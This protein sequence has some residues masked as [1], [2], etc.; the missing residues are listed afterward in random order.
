MIPTRL[1]GSLEFKG[2][3]QWEGANR[4]AL[5]VLRNIRERSPDVLAHAIAG[6]FLGVI[7]TLQWGVSLKGR[8]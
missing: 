6:V 4:A 8:P 3:T 2:R 5:A 7:P 1:D